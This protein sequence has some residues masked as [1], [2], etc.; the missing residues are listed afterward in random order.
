MSDWNRHSLAAHGYSGCIGVSAMGCQVDSRSVAGFPSLSPL[1]IAVTG[2]I[3]NL[4]VI[5][6]LGF[7]I[8]REY[9]LELSWQGNWKINTLDGK[10]VLT[11]VTRK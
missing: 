7:A 5:G 10:I 3:V 11:P 1:R 6:L 4:I 2:R 8:S 9:K